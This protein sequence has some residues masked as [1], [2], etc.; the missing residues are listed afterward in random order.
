MSPL[1]LFGVILHHPR[2]RAFDIHHTKWPVTFE[3]VFARFHHMVEVPKVMLIPQIETEC[4]GGVNLWNWHLPHLGAMVGLP[5]GVTDFDLRMCWAIVVTDVRFWRQVH[6]SCTIGSSS[7]FLRF[8]WL[9][10]LFAFW[11]VL[12]VLF[13]TL[14]I[15]VHELFVVHTLLNEMWIQED[16]FVALKAHEVECCIWPATHG[17]DE[18]IGLR[19]NVSDGLYVTRFDLIHTDPA[20]YNH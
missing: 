10:T 4:N 12:V 11:K 16:E 6:T 1:L 18:N 20:R 2:L 13:E 15:V 9:F 3:F 17:S 14:P 8:R 19:E 7:T 5:V